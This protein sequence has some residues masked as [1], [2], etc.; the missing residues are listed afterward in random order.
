MCTNN[1]TTTKRTTLTAIAAIFLAATLVV[2]GTLVVTTTAAIRPAYA[3]TFGSTKNLSNNDGD[4]TNPQVQVSSSNVYAVWEDKTKG[5]GDTF[6]RR[7]SDAGNN[8]HSIIDLS[9]NAAGEAKGI[10]PDQKI[11]KIGNNVYVV[12]SENGDVFFKRST[13][14]G[15]HFGSTI[16]LSNDEDN[17]T[18]P[19]IAAVGNNVYVAWLNHD[20]DDDHLIFFKRST[21]EGASFGS[22]KILSDIVEEFL[23]G[24]RNFHIAATGNNVYVAWIGTGEDHGQ[25]P[26]TGDLEFVRST[27]SGSS[28]G[29]VNRIVQDE[30][31]TPEGLDLEATGSNV[32]LTWSDRPSESACDIN[33]RCNDIL[34]VKSTDN[35]A[36]FGSIKNLSNNDGNSNPGS[37]NPQMDLHG[38]N[39][40]IVW[41]DNTLGNFD[42]LFRV[43]TNNGSTF[44][45]TKNLSNNAGN[46]INAQISSVSDAVRIVWQDNTLGD[47]D[48]FFKAS[49]NEGSTFGSTKN[50]SNNDGDSSVPQIISSGDNI[51]VVWQD[52]TP[53]NFDILFKKGVD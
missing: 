35:G 22:V 13:D 5:D 40:Y 50:L 32:Y 2:G 27:N 8:F 34:F 39:V 46:S 18:D 25:C 20:S 10:V 30:I 19:Q 12:W 24:F 51:Y 28:F 33:S 52:D 16:N 9:N 42:I 7:S 17:S 43:S 26:E 41:Q 31:C 44:A 23:V 45:S 48:I 38:S 14:N 49:G 15:A 37:V 36:H 11:A 3:I 1:T 29:S 6:F 47:S 53:G 21:N 4:S